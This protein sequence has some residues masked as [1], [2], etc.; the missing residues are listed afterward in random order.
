MNQKS[1][2]TSFW[3]VFLFVLKIT[4]IGFGGG[5]A[6]MP[7]IKNEAVD[8][9]KWLTLEEFDK[10]VIV[11][12]M[13]PGP[14]V[15]QSI[16]YICIKHFGKF[17]GSILTLVAILPHVLMAFGLYLGVSKLPLQYLYVIAAG[18]L[19]AISGVLF[20]F[21]WSYMKS[22]KNKINTPLWLFLFIFTFAFCFFVPTP[23]N[24]PVIVMIAIFFIVG[25]IEFVLYRKAKK[26]RSNKNNNNE[27]QNSNNSEVA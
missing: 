3:E 11:T 1:R 2:K 8:R 13:L 21:G 23:Y 24:I 20:A 6:L 22:S 9:K 15:I 7:V 25:I 27:T 5:N 19:T 26:M 4:F 12:N 16:S 10:M 14:S 17:L 18:V